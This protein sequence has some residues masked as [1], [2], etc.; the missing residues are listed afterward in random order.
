[1][2]NNKPTIQ[3]NKIDIRNSNKKFI[4]PF[5]VLLITVV[6]LIIGIYLLNKL[7][8]AEINTSIENEKEEV[9]SNPTKSSSYPQETVA[10]QNIKTYSSK[11]GSFSIDLPLNIVITESESE[12]INGYLNDE[13]IFTF[14]EYREPIEGQTTPPMFVISFAKP[15]VIGKGGACTIGYTEIDI[16]NQEVT[17]C[18]NAKEFNVTYFKHSEK[19][20]EY[21][22]STLNLSEEEVSIIRKAVVD[23]FKLN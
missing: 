21:S 4:T 8:N 22:M 19:Q 15:E 14:G 3:D 12:Y 5:V 13:V 10:E 2:N 18:E 20:I 9:V 6:T 1:M 11:E 16:A 23:S 17:V 7:R